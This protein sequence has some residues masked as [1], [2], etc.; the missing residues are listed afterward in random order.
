MSD[1]NVEFA[2][3]L[4]CGHVLRIFGKGTI[5]KCYKCSEDPHFTRVEFGCSSP[6]NFITSNGIK[7]MKP[8]ISYD[9]NLDE[10]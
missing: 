4:N 8:G 1:D 10:K 7:T 6:V 5:I 3:C 2:A 9:E